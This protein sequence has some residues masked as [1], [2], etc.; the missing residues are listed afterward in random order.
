MKSNQKGFTLIELLAVIVILAII[1]LIATPLVLNII[2]KARTS[3]AQDSVYGVMEATRLTYNESLLDA[4]S[5]SLPFTVTCTSSD[6]TYETGKMKE[7]GTT[8]DT[9]PITFG[10]SKPTAGV[11]TL[12]TDGKFVATPKKDDDTFDY[13]V[14]NNINCVIEADQTVS[15]GK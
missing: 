10:G 3:A 1:A 12:G 9:Q 4:T 8:K 2:S 15:C 5:I 14:V 11:F 7:D 6:C 13:I